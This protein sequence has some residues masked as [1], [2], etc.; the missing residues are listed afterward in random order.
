VVLGAGFKRVL[1]AAQAG[2]EAAFVRLWR[3]ANPVMTRYLRVAGLDDPY[4]AACEGWI[5]VVR[6]LSGFQGDET[7][8]RLWVLACARV[9]AEES[10][11]R[12]SWGSVTVL[13]GV[14]SEPGEEPLELD[15]LETTG[16]PAHRGVGEAIA[17]IRALPLGQGEIVMLRL[18]A[19][20]PVAAVA[21]VVGTDAAAV[22]RTETRALERLEI[23]RELLGWSLT[24][25]ATPAEL[26]DERVVTGAF[27]SLP[28]NG[29]HPADRGGARVIALGPRQG[30]PQR[31]RP[32]GWSRSALVGAAAVTASVVS[33]GGLGAAAYTGSLPDPVQRVMHDALGAPAPR[34]GLDQGGK[35]TSTPGGSSRKAGPSSVPGSAVGPDAGTAAAGGLCRAWAQD[36]AKG[37]ARGRSVAYRNL[38]AA[39]GGADHV[40]DYCAAAT[41]D[42]AVHPAKPTP[43]GSAQGSATHPTGPADASSETGSKGSHAPSAPARPTRTS[44]GA[45]SNPR[46]TQS[47][48]PTSQHSGKGQLR[49]TTPTGG[50]GAADTTPDTTPASSPD[51][52][53]DHPAGKASTIPSATGKGQGR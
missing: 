28:H 40:T 19:E 8:W 9:R 25:P 6:G 17:A 31:A 14:W 16:D 53:P 13:P 21:H 37:V 4:D 2:D 22:R 24:A 52:T 29:P 41:A 44:K 27:R 30:R 39:A 12:R 50:T 32:A 45:P 23:D 35:G 10:S 33:L 47:G 43:D 38:A 51:A 7:D 1:R 20:L 5:T 48:S 18:C 3:D 11:L 49:S 26:A 42:K 15:D 34:G 46:S 36:E